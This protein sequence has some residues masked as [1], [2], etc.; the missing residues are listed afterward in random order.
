METEN[1]ENHYT[2]RNEDEFTMENTK[3]V[4]VFTLFYNNSGYGPTLQ[5]YA[6][7][8]K[9]NEQGFDACVIN[10]VPKE[11]SFSYRLVRLL[12]H[13][14]RIFRVLNRRLC[15]MKSSVDIVKKEYDSLSKGKISK[16]KYFCDN[17]I[18]VT[19][20]VTENHLYKSNMMDCYD[21]LLVGSDQVWNPHFCSKAHFLPFDKKGRRKLAY[22]ASISVPNLTKREKQLFIKWLPDFDYITVRENEGKQLLE[23]FLDLKVETVLDP[24]LLLTSDDWSKLVEPISLQ[25]Q[26]SYRK[27]DKNSDNEESKYILF[28]ALGTDSSH[29]QFAMHIARRMNMRLKILSTSLDEMIANRDL[30]G[31]ELVDVS[32]NEYLYLVKNAALVITDSFHC[33]AFSINFHRNFFVLRRNSDNDAANM[34]S[35]IYTILSELGL[36]S[37][38]VKPREADTVVIPQDLYSGVDEKLNLLRKRSENIL[39]KMLNG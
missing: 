25:N 33:T 34:N 3:K 22:A 37:Q 11:L 30:P 5:A 1:T 27:S 29:R 10:F 2:F 8:K 14:Q 4:G 6:L 15:F 7:Q 23:S 35:R 21:I 31:D 19:E 13:P 39:A 12:S 20:P 17:N 18:S 36:E 24:T 38:L 28:A 26:V 32:Q 9:I 16:W